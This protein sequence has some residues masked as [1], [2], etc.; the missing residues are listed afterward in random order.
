MKLRSIGLSAVLALVF[1][2][3]GG[4]TPEASGPSEGIQVHGDWTIDIYDEDGSL[5]KHV[6]FT[7]HLASE[8]AETLARILSGEVE[9]GSWVIQW[10]S[11]T[12][13]PPCGICWDEATVQ[14][15]TGKLILAASAEADRDGSIDQVSSLVAICPIDS[16][17]GYPELPEFTSTEVVDPS[18]G[19]GYEVVSG[20]S[21]AI[22]VTISF[23]SG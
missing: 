10:G 8:G 9:Q 12:N 17:A 15:D 5:D 23:T 3:C 1:V 20:Q 4:T 22:G 21:Y 18:T 2:S 7:N 11:S 16:C 14:R 13:T 6:E 19:V